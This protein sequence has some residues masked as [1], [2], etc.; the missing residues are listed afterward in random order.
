MP[1][2]FV[3]LRVLHGPDAKAF[4]GQ[5]SQGID[6]GLVEWTKGN[7][8]KTRIFQIPAKGTRTVRYA[9]DLLTDENGT[10]YRLP[11]AFHDRV[12]AGLHPHTGMEV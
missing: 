10:R 2:C 9:A 12:D 4:A 3:P 5:V 1:C 8:F 6:P 11:L 7:N